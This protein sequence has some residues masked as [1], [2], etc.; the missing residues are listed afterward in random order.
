MKKKKNASQIRHI[1]TEMINVL[2]LKHQEEWFIL[3]DQR[4]DGSASYRLK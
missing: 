2:N 3:V 1:L 4:M